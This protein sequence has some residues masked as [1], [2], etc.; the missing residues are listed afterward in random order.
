MGNMTKRRVS[1]RKIKW[2]CIRSTHNNYKFL[3]NIIKTT[4]PLLKIVDY[5]NTHF[6]HFITT[7]CITLLD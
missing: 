3:Y 2:N 1:L 5:F 4:T 7:F 6:I